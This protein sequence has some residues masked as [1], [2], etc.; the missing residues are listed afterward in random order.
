MLRKNEELDTVSVNEYIF[1]I[2]C[3]Q[4]INE[5]EGREVRIQLFFNLNKF[6]E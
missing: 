2:D 1:E 5:V 6:F 3:L 4:T